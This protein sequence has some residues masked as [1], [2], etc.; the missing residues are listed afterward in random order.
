MGFEFIRRRNDRF[1]RQRDARFVEQIEPDLFSACVPSTVVNVCGTALCHVNDNQELWT[2]DVGPSGPICFYSG[3]V[4]AV[5]LEGAP[6]DHVRSQ[7][8]SQHAPVVAQVM[9]VERDHGLVVLRVGSG[10]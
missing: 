5:R 10:P 1:I 9:T 7:P 8:R 4:P 3:D 6:A 2:P